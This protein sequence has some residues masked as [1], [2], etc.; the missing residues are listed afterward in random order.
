MT[1][2]VPAAL[3]I[4]VLGVVAG[5]GLE[6]VAVA[7][8][9]AAA[10]PPAPSPDSEIVRGVWRIM[11]GLISVGFLAVLAR[12]FFAM[13]T[14]TRTIKTM[15]EEAPK[16][17]EEISGVNKALMDFVEKVNGRFEDHGGRIRVVE[18][19]VGIP[20]PRRRRDDVEERE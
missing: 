2:P 11:S 6:Q 20:A 15:E 5:V 19:R 12:A 17:R 10:A 7:A 3:S 4:V 18:D 9:Q 14:I 13:G 16:L 8:T 1:I